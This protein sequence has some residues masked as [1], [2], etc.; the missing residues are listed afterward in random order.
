M[1]AFYGAILIK[2]QYKGEIKETLTKINK[3]IGTK[4]YISPAIDGWVGVYPDNHGQDETISEEMAGEI[5]NE[6]LQLIVHDDDIFIYS[7]H[8]DG[9]LIDKYNSNPDYFGEVSEDEKEKV[10]GNP[11]VFSG[12]FSSEQINSLEELLE[13]ENVKNMVFTTELLASF[14]DI[15]GL[16]NT[17]TSYEYLANGETEDI[18]K[19]D[20]FEKIG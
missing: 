2:S 16:P 19:W 10:K 6:M 20:E 18:R 4:F 7:F 12:L 3:S 5:K 8:K 9:R 17:L 14:S 15:L 13:P 1:G 11:V